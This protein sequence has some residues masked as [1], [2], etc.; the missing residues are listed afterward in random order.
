[1]EWKDERFAEQNI[2]RKRNVKYDTRISEVKI[3]LVSKIPVLSG[4]LFQYRSSY[5]IY[6]IYGEC[7][8]NEVEKQQNVPQNALCTNYKLIATISCI[9]V[10]N[11]KRWM[12]PNY[13]TITR[14]PDTIPP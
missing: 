11:E 13:Y 4:S 5:Q 12:K 3:L 9:S 10:Q 6:R 8:G 1:M 2:Q 14:K 7:K